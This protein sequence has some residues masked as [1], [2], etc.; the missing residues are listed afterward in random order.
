MRHEDNMISGPDTWYS[1]YFV[2][3]SCWQPGCMKIC[4]QRELLS[5]DRSFLTDPKQEAAGQNL[6]YAIEFR[7]LEL[8]TNLNRQSSIMPGF[9]GKPPVLGLALSAECHF[10][11][12]L[13][14]TLASPT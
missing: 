5:R 10:I 9:P 12:S 14:Q 11:P 1:T 6:P 13:Y 2:V 8:L 3:S 4:Q 7:T